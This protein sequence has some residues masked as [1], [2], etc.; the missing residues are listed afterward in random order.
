VVLLDEIDHY[1]QTF[2]DMN[3]NIDS[4]T[5]E[6]PFI[7]G[8]GTPAPAQTCQQL[9]ILR[10]PES[11]QYNLSRNQPFLCES[12]KVIIHNKN[13][14]VPKMFAKK[15]WA[16]TRSVLELSWRVPKN[17]YSFFCG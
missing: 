15:K 12:V 14:L 17:F 13:I 7:K 3:I 1:G 11:F 16:A 8:V 4:L 6:S 9:C 10:R 2:V 5:L